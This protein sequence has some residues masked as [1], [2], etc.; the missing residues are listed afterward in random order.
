MIERDV[1]FVQNIDFFDVSIDKNSENVS[2][3]FFEN[4]KITDDATTNFDDVT[5]EKIIDRKNEKDFDSKTNETNEIKNEIT[6]ST[7]C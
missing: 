4:I 5:N 1:I 6:N 2:K 7:N 3:K